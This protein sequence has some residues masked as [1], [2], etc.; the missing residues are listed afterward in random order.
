MT[1]ACTAFTLSLASKHAQDA[2]QSVPPACELIGTRYGGAKASTTA[3]TP[4]AAVQ[5]R[6]SL[7]IVAS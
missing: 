1:R 7:N 4:P 5:R 6:V 2:Q 3:C